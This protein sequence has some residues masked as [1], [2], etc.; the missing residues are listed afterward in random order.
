MNNQTN[1]V[2]AL[3]LLSAEHR[4]AF[5]ASC[6]ER[7]L[8]N[9]EAFVVQEKFGEKL[10]LRNALDEVWQYL[11]GAN[12]SNEHVHNLI[13]LLEDSAPSDLENEF[14]SIF[15]TAAQEAIAAV[16]YTLECCLK[17]TADILTKVC[18]QLTATLEE[19]LSIVNS[20][21]AGNGV[22]MDDIGWIYQSPL[23]ISEENKKRQDLE[24]L[25]SRQIVDDFV[26]ETLRHSATGVGIQP[27]RRNLCVELIELT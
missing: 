20:P 14:R 7:L 13:Q 6:C 12:I 11:K 24:F 21:I 27:F 3:M 9:Y 16:S 8:P 22:D 19:Y 18:D 15:L 2:D 17:P 26:I 4:I 25:Q 10:L 23:F 5:A 1:T